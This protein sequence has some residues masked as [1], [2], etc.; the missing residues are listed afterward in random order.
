MT[1]TPASDGREKGVRTTGRRDHVELKEVL[2]E[3]RRV[4]KAIRVAAIDPITNTEVIMVGAL[5]YGR[6]LL[7]R[8]AMRKLAYVIRKKRRRGMIR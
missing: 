2:F 6:E 7:K 8:L 5:G 3:F 4:G 1:E